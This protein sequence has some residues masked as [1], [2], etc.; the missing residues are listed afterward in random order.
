MNPSDDPLAYLDAVFL[1]PHKFIGGPGTP[2][3]LALRREL[4][5]NAVPTVPGG[6]TVI[7]VNANEHRY[8]DDIEQRE[9]GGTPAIIE[10]IRAGL[11]FQVKEAVGSAVIRKCEEAFIRRAIAAWD[12][13][14]SLEILGNKHSERLSIVS[15]VV[16]HGGRY[17]HHSFVVALLNDLFGIQA[18]GGCSC[19]GPYGHRLL[20]IDI[21]RSHQFEREISRGCEGI[22]PGWVRVNFNYF[23][24]ERVFEYIVEAVKVVAEDGWR[25]LP[26]LPLRPDRGPV[27]PPGRPRGAAAVAERGPLRGRRDGR[28]TP[29]RPRAD[30]RSRALPRRGP[31]SARLAVRR[32]RRAARCV[33]LHFGGVRGPAL[34]L[35]SGVLRR[36]RG[37]LIGPAARRP[38]FVRNKACGPLPGRPVR[39]ML[40]PPF[41]ADLTMKQNPLPA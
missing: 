7:Y 40:A 28:A 10:S 4:C 14:R 23:I 33:S 12:G 38:R 31:R 41:A 22:K 17:L 18:R 19:A 20:G 2:G 39:A 3:V 24:D 25:L 35:A 21:D 37:P 6:G 9:E 34:V 8:I 26:R 29:R 32:A 11:V 36:R 15:F 30:R 27:A 13:C 16:K 5:K 1:S